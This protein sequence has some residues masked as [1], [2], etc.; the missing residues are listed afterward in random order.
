[1]ENIYDE[2]ELEEY[3]DVFKVETERF[4]EEI[5]NKGFNKG[6][7]KI[8]EYLNCAASLNSDKYEELFGSREITD[9]LREFTPTNFINIMDSINASGLIEASK[10]IKQYTAPK[11]FETLKQIDEYEAGIN[12][13][14]DK[15]KKHAQTEIHLYYF[16]LD[17]L[18]C[19]HS[20]LNFYNYEKEKCTG[21][22]SQGVVDLYESLKKISELS[23]DDHFRILE[24]GQYSIIEKTPEELIQI[25]KPYLEKKEDNND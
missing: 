3:Y 20:I 18:L 14:W 15:L 21:L 5:F 25:M 24:T 10:L 11:I 16:Q 17:A 13:L 6:M 8:W 1:M 23:E 9:I 7:E 19:K 12:D 4:V 2:K 22:Y